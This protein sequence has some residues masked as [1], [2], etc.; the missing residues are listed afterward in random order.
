VTY[1]P[2][3]VTF[4]FACQGHPVS[5][6]RMCPTHAC[7]EET[8]SLAEADPAVI[9]YQ[10]LEPNGLLHSVSK[11]PMFPAAIDRWKQ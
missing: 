6:I 8:I 11:I 2:V 5:S 7:V 4:F 9:R 10:V 3:I 1:W